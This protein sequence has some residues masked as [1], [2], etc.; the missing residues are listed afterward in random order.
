M[1]TMILLACT[2]SSEPAPAEAAAEPAEVASSE[3]AA[4]PISAPPAAPASKP[5]PRKEKTASPCDGPARLD[6][7]LRDLAEAAAAGTAPAT[8][9]TVV[10]TLSD[11]A[12][13]PDLLSDLVVAGPLVQGTIPADQLCDLAAAPGVE[14]LRKPIEARPK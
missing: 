11:G 13:P 12:A 4:E 1:L 8:P 5:P 2:H 10:V 9:V 6:A 7:A 3:P 14:S